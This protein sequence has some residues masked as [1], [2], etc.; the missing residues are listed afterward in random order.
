MLDPLWAIVRQKEEGAD[1]VRQDFQSLFFSDSLGEDSVVGVVVREV[2]GGKNKEF[3]KSCNGLCSLPSCVQEI[4]MKHVIY[5]V[6][7]ICPSKFTLYPSLACSF[8][9]KAGL[10]QITS[11]HHLVHWLLVGQWVP[12]RASEDVRRVRL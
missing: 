3:Y 11:L 2:D 8:L 6:S 1:G 7:S 4:S 12:S 5:H 10:I 9:H